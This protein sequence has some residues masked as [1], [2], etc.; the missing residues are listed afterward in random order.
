MRSAVAIFSQQ[1]PD[2]ALPTLYA[3]TAPDVSGGEYFGPQG[4]GG[5]TGPPGRA[6]S[7]PSSRD[8]ALA[9]RLWEASE[10]LTGLSYGA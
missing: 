1:P 8:A 9:G 7:S 4:L 3:A 5:A 6:S 10:R 2:G